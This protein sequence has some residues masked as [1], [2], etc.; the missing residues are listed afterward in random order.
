MDYAIGALYGSLIIGTLCGM[1]P[2]IAGLMT[3]NRSYAF[4]GLVA[5]ILAGFILG[6]I[7]ALPVAIIS[8]LFALKKKKPVIAKSV[9]SVLKFKCPSC[10]QSLEAEDDGLGDSSE[11][12]SCGFNIQ[13]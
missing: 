8:T 6:V 10:G 12:P 2:M 9:K 3:G 7:G 5:C 11:C 1:L 13:I 4:G